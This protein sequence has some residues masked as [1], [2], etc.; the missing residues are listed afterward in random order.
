MP[1]ET[2]KNTNET[3]NL[4]KGVCLFKFNQMKPIFAT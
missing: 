2:T 4:M 1:T 3:I